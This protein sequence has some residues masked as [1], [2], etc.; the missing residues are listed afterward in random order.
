MIARVPAHSIRSK[1]VKENIH[2]LIA[3]WQDTVH[4]G[5]N[6]PFKLAEFSND[7]SFW[8]ADSRQDGAKVKY[9]RDRLEAEIE[10][11]II[12]SAYE[13]LLKQVEQLVGAMKK[14]GNAEIRRELGQ[15]VRELEESGANLLN[16][17]DA[18][19]YPD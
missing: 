18:I 19:E 8:L 6:R 7:D 9:S 14:T 15:K 4:P 1:T 10:M 12:L 11:Q 17:L 5:Q 2:D 3:H 16:Q 13:S